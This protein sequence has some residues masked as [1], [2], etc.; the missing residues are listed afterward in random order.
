MYLHKTK[1]YLNTRALLSAMS[2]PSDTVINDDFFQKNGV[3]RLSV[4]FPKNLNKWQEPDDDLSKAELDTDN[5]TIKL[6]IK[7]I[8]QYALVVH[9]TVH[10]LTQNVPNVSNTVADAAWLPVPYELNGWIEPGW[11]YDDDAET[12]IPVSLQAVKDEAIRRISDKANGYQ[13]Q[14]IG[15]EDA[16]RAKRFEM[17]LAAAKA[18]QAGIATE[19]Q[20]DMLKL[21]LDANKYAEHPVLKDATLDEFAQWIVGYDDLTTQAIGL[22]ENVLIVGRAQVNKAQ[23]V[24]EIDAI[25]K[26]LA[27]Q[28]EE[29]F[30]LLVSGGA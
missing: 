15:T 13:R 29:Q 30:Q 9:D 3:S 17:N 16:D 20:S 12:F 23:S 7:N 28:A 19:A 24:T 5:L 18:L 21:Q 4:I 11:H 8:R 6:A 1:P 10:L 14:I 22:I 27:K 25:I 26:Q 2:M